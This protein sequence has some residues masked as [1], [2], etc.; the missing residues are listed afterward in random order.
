M[1]KSI[2][3]QNLPSKDQAAFLGDARSR[4][5]DIDPMGPAFQVGVS[6]WHVGWG[7]ERC[8]WA[9]TGGCPCC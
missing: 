9:S 1:S 2:R 7:C 6:P 5:P 8:L 4:Y 3:F